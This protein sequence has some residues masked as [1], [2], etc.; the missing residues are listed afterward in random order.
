MQALFWMLQREQGKH[1]L[2]EERDADDNGMW[3]KHFFTDKTPFYF[4]PLFRLASLEDPSHLYKMKGGIIADEMGLGKTITML[5]LLLMNR[6]NAHESISTTQSKMEKDSL[7]HLELPIRFEGGSLIVCPLSLLYL[8]QTEIVN[9]LEPGALRCCVY[10]NGSL[11]TVCLGCTP[12]KLQSCLRYDVVLTTYDSCAA[13]FTNP[14]DNILYTTRWKRVIIDEGHIIKNDKLLLFIP[15]SYRT[16][17]HKAVVALHSEIHWVLTG[18]PLQNTV[19]DLYSLFRFLRY[20][21]WCYVR[22]FF[23]LRFRKM[24]GIILLTVEKKR[25]KVLLRREKAKSI[26]TWILT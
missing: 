22:I 8:W 11:Y 5:S 15:P 24:S 19:N 1:V 2:H 14:Q 20:E 12:V 3:E 6:G 9:H 4:C 18:T 13:A 23:F 7:S 21:P 25:R 17:V 10:H 16:L 26:L